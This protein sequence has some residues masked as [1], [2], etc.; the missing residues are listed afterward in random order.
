MLKGVRQFLGSSA[1]NR[2]DMLLK[3]K[4]LNLWLASSKL[5]AVFC[6]PA[7]ESENNVFQTATQRLQIHASTVPHS[8]EKFGSMALQFLGK[9]RQK[10]EL[11]DKNLQ[12]YLD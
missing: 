12:A 5:T 4:K 6:E 9:Q 10:K 11:D 2:M 7:L 3:G 8:G 1:P